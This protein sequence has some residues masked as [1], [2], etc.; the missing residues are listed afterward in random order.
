MVHTCTW[1]EHIKALRELFARLFRA[2]MTIRPSRCIFGASCIDFLGLCLEQGVLGLH[3][4]N[5]EKIK[6]APRPSTKNEVVTLSLTLQ[7]LQLLLPTIYT[8]YKEYRISLL[9]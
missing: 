1:E 9:T 6:I 2:G 3:E 8:N 7:L 5:V 4:D